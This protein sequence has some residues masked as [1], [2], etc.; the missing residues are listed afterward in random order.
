MLGGMNLPTK[1]NNHHFLQWFP[2]REFHVL[3]FFFFNWFF[4][5][6]WLLLLKLALLGLRHVRHVIF[7]LELQA[8]N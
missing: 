4:W 6:L 8:E 2:H 5:F 3:L 1:S 7:V